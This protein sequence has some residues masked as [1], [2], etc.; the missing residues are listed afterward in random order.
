MDAKYEWREVMRK[1]VAKIIAAIIIL[2]GVAILYHH[3]GFGWLNVLYATILA[4]FP[5]EI[6][7][8]FKR[9]INVV[10]GTRSIR[11]SFSYLFRIQYGDQYLL[12]KDEQGRNSYHPVGGVY[13]YNPNEIDISEEFDGE[14]DGLFGMSHDTEND[15]RLKVGKSKLTHFLKWFSTGKGRENWDNLSREFSEELIE[16]GILQEKDFK[17]I[18]YKYIGSISTK[19]I[20]EDLQI[21]QL[22]HF[23]IFSMRLTNA[24]KS[25]LRLLMRKQSQAYVFAS[26]ADIENGYISFAGERY[27]IAETSK[28]ILVKNKHVLNKEYEL[29]KEI[30]TYLQNVALPH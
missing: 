18:T 3:F 28:F 4:L 24:Q 21:P 13:K 25:Q 5:N 27:K 16:K 15:I 30:A 23:D 7:A 20:N 12:V 29:N 11:V 6:K 9:I 17:K 1:L 10:S 2:V 14:Y 8:L 22:H 19:S 26:E